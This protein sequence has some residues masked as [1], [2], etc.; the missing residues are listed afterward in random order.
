MRRVGVLLCS[1]CFFV[2]VQGQQ[3]LKVANGSGT[4]VLIDGRIT[5]DE[6]HDAMTV[7]LEPT[8]RLHL[9]QFKGHV[10]LALKTERGSPVYVDLF[11]E[12]GDKRLHN[13]HA[14]MQIGERLLTGSDWTDSS[15]PTNWGNHVDW[16]ANEAKT[17][18]QKDQR[19]PFVKQLFPYDGMEFQILSTKF[20]GRKWRLRIEVR[21]F[22]G[23][24]PD[25]VFPAASDRRNTERW[26]VLDLGAKN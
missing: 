6:W 20:V 5:D 21:D 8:I 16:I 14:S 25:K 23:Q 13:L 19:L 15:P 22:A 4:P 17:D 11:I 2:V 12:D 18:G 10:Y 24:L 7:T 9:K 26:F 3:I 1:L